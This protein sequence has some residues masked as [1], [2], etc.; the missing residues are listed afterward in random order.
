MLFT[1]PHLL[2]TYLN[3][4]SGQT[5]YDE[6]FISLYNTFFTACPNNFRA[7]AD[8]IIHPELDGK[9]LKSKMPDIYYTGRL[10]TIFTNKNFAYWFGW[11]TV[12]A[13]LV[14]F[15]PFGCVY[16]SEILDSSGRVADHWFFANTSG[17]AI[18]LI[19]NLKLWIIS[20]YIACWNLI[21]FFGFSF[22]LYQAY[23]W[24]CEFSYWSNINHTVVIMHTTPL[25]YAT[26]LCVVIMC[27]VFDIIWHKVLHVLEPTP[28]QYLFS[29]AANKEY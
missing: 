2:F 9:E 20:R 23:L 18:L 6:W 25:M 10:N 26:T 16:E 24:V 27:H 15:I 8:L 7:C 19:G 4:F 12:Q 11:G 22:I 28:S 14:F 29:M 1:V 5:V 17:L 13:I 21:A 3:L